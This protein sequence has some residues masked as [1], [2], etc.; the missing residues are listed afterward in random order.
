[1]PNR[2]RIHDEGTCRLLAEL[3]AM[4]YIDPEMEEL[5]SQHVSG[6]LADDERSKFE[7][8]L[9][10][11]SGLAAEVRRRQTELTAHLTTTRLESVAT[12]VL[13]HSEP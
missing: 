3:N 2:E 9:E 1:M 6:L 7:A 8:R 12:A 5:I 11:D 10:K 13:D 4:P